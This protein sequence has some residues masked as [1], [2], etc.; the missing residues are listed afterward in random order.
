MSESKAHY[1]LD[2]SG[3][4]ELKLTYTLTTGALDVLIN[5]CTNVARAR[6]NQASDP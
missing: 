1:G 3:T 6:K 4:I 5:K 2:V